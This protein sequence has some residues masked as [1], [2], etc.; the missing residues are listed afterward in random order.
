MILSKA[1]TLIES[2]APIILKRLKKYLANYCLLQEI[3]FE[4]ALLVYLV[5]GKVHLLKNSV[6]YYVN[7][8]IRWRYLPLIQVQ[9]LVV[10]VL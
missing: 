2:N 8:D 6:C 3:Q 4:L 9:V 10:A 1:I 5:Q 7:E